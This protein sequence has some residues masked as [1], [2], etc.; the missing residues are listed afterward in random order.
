M[1]VNRAFTVKDLEEYDE[2][3][4]PA[5]LAYVLPIWCYNNNNECSA[6]L[7]HWLLNQEE[8]NDCLVL[9]VQKAAGGHLS[10]RWVDLIR[11]DKD[12]PNK[13]ISTRIAITRNKKRSKPRVRA[14]FS[15]DMR[16]FAEKVIADIAV[17]IHNTTPNNPDNF[18]GT[19]FEATESAMALAALPYEEKPANYAKQD[20]DWWKD[21]NRRR[22][23]Y[24][25]R[26]RRSATVTAAAAEVVLTPG[27]TSSSSAFLPPAAQAAPPPLPPPPPSSAPWRPPLP[28]T[29]WRPPL[30]PT[31]WRPPVPK[32]PVPQLPNRWDNEAVY[33]DDTGKYWLWVKELGAKVADY[34][35][36]TGCW[37]FDPAYES[38][39][40]V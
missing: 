19:T 30:P 27:A 6:M 35:T 4:R 5:T 3:F 29:P 28:P 25:S 16:E 32:D 39:I 17:F 7:Y 24:V 21:P 20:H 38:I 37:V 18:H 36:S 13:R 26:Y 1:L 15:P 8:Y 33:Y 9:V 10:E 34:D 31:P 40:V 2:S 22:D 14:D 23:D 12:N 11:Q